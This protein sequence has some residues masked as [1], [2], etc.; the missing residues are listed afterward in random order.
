MMTG[1]NDFIRLPDRIKGLGELASN[2]WWSWRP[3]ARMLF[4]MLDRQ[5]WKESRHNPDKMLRELSAESLSAAA[6]NPEYLRHYDVVM[7]IFESYMSR[8]D[9]S[10]VNGP[11]EPGTVAV[12]YFSAEYGL[13]RSLP[14][15]AGGL[16]FLAGDFLK[17]CSDLNIP[18]A[19][20][21]FMYPEGYLLQKIREDGW[22]ENINEPFDREAASISRVLREDGSQF[23]VKVPMVDPPIYIAVWKVDVGSNTLYL[24]DTDIEQNDPW[25]RLFSARLY[26]GDLEQRLRQE[27]VLGIGGAEMLEKLGI[28]Y[29]MIHLNEGHAA[30]A[31]LERI[32]DCINSGM[33]F[34]E[35]LK[36]VKDTTVFTTHTPVAAGHDVF[37]FHMMEKYF[38]PYWSDLGLDRERFLQLGINPKN[39][40]QGF[41]MTVLALNISAYRNAVSRRH[42]EV[43]RK[44]WRDLWPDKPV[45]KI[46]I[47]AINNGVHVRT[48]VEPKMKLLYDRYLG[49]GWIEDHDNPF[50]WELIEKIPDQELWHTHYWLKIKLIDA[51]RERCRKRWATDR[52]SP[53]IL[54][55]GGAMLDPSVLTIGFARRFATY[56]RA[57]LIFY[58]LSRL[59]RLLND[60]RQPIQ[61]IFAGK[62]H[63]S[64]EPGKRILQK[65]YNACRDPEMGGRIAFVEDYGEQIA[66]YL[67]HGVDVWLNNPLPPMEASGTSGMKAALNGV[68]QLSILDGWWI[69]GYNG[70][71]GWAFGDKVN[72]GNRDAADAEAIYRILENDIIPL[73]YRISDDGIPR[74]WVRIMK[75][76]IR[77]N[78]AR[79]SSRRMVKEYLQKF[80][81]KTLR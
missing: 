31:L 61:I 52:G 78:A 68:P 28:R 40:Q 70:K 75:E 62:A 7:S 23:I 39:P 74:E 44:M 56:K 9:Y 60:R 18:M 19:A 12:A 81:S 79:F 1:E 67:V 16:G 13:H 3:R 47:D 50:V 64:D 49:A 30:F 53:S 72:E 2:L 63:P 17:E 45:E 14:F 42:A 27:I 54:L 77:S 8:K 15:Y 80:Y 69:E 22:Q 59:K 58:D 26:S 32:R 35:A 51:I 43:S 11:L 71:N 4:K 73:Y 34:E 76:A 29:R 5:A 65:V 66:Q 6:E 33:T 20:V 37:L 21:G 55:S 38:H 36:N 25:N 46:P 57:D 48:W 24:M 10:L 41:N